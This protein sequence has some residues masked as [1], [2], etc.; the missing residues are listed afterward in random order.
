MK[1]NR[2]ILIVDRNRH[3]REF[4]KRELEASGYL[5]RTAGDGKECLKIAHADDSLDLLVLDLDLPP[6][7]GL[8]LLERLR[9]LRPLMPV[10]IYSHFSELASHP[11]ALAAKAFVDKNESLEHLKKAMTS[12]LTET[13]T[14]RTF[15]R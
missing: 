1:E 7:S 12:A 11:T 5:V 3:L 9:N 6:N 15:S 8:E 14:D 13:P 4:L 10:V 2:K